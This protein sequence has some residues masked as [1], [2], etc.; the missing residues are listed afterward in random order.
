MITSTRAGAGKTTVA[1]GQSLQWKEN[2]LKIG[3]FKPWADRI[4][5]QESDALDKDSV[6]F[7]QTLALQQA[8]HELSL[9]YNYPKLA[10]DNRNTEEELLQSLEERHNQLAN[11]K[12]CLIV[13]GPRNCFHG[14]YAELGAGSIAR[15]LDAE[16]ILVA[17]GDSSLVADRIIAC[18]RLFRSFDVKVRG[19][20]VN[21][22]E[23]PEHVHSEL[24]PP[25]KRKGIEILTVLPEISDL[26]SLT[27]RLI[28][29]GLGAS[30][31]AGE[32]GL[33]KQ[34]RNTHVGAM[35]ISKALGPMRKFKDIALITGGDRTDMQL[36]AF[37]VSIN[38]FILTGGIYPEP[39]V[40][41]KAD[42]LNVPVLL[43]SE[44]TYQ[45]A[46]KIEHMVPTVEARDRDKIR[47]IRKLIGNPL[48]ISTI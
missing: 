5:Y 43:V 27:P 1:L 21:R 34:I 24:E 37:E 39:T 35:T 44:F 19:V 40:L 15:R 7:A 13:E 16:T 33:D 30:V 23:D 36:A 9:I 18:T 4:Q 47:K 11:D 2:G 17:K 42:D 10:G 6:L 38:C 20:I 45:T 8:P 29:N 14:T 48:N 46:R 25:L 26:A 41:A 3:Y 22:A 31:L 12:D 32:E 28:A